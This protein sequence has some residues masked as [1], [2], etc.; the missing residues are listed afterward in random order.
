[1]CREPG[2][3]SIVLLSVALVAFAPARTT[4]DGNPKEQ[5]GDL[6]QDG[7]LDRVEQELAERYAPLLLLD[8][9]EPNLPM[10]VSR[11]L[12]SAELW[13]YDESCSP[14]RA[15]IPI[16][17][18]EHIAAASF[19]SC[20][21]FRVNSYGTRSFEKK[22]TYY[23]S[24]VSAGLRRGS[25][26]TSGWT[27]YF[28]AYR[29]DLGGITIQYWTFYG[30]NTGF[31]WGIRSPATSHEGDWEAIHIVLGRP[32]F[33]I[34]VLIRL[35]GHR[36]MEA[37]PWTDVITANGHPII[38]VEKG[39]HTSALAS[40][41]EVADL[42]RFIQHQSWSGGSVRWASKRWTRTEARVTPGG[43]LRNL[44][45]KTAPMK[46][47]EFLLYTGLWGLRESGLFDYYRSGYWGPA[48][49]ETSIRRD[50]FVAAW[51]EGTAE[52]AR[53]VRRDGIGVVRECYPSESVP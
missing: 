49:N 4:Q 25:E 6:D 50:G 26:S 3:C 37:H 48:L 31:F 13:S 19:R 24:A 46:G 32:P 10:D 23:L 35:L 43:A 11:F 30:Y 40:Q 36:N 17:V 15:L 8:G 1:M 45:E 53:E 41:A 28:H 33:S 16:P 9:D 18:S 51:C 22:H 42:S 29:N 39:G 21:G 34:P 52:P 7:I 12:A 38:R 5:P 27:T 14:T 44:G 2:R 20:K 47:M